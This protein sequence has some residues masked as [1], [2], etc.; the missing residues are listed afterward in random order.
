MV[1]KIIGAVAGVALVACGFAV[2]FGWLTA[3]CWNHFPFLEQAHHM[4][5]WDGIVIQLL[6]GLLVKTSVSSNSSS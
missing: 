4:S 5:W 2:L 6:S 1:A 3:L